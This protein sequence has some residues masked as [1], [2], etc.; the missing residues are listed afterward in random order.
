MDDFPDALF[1]LLV[2]IVGTIVISALWE[3]L[4]ERANSTEDHV[5]PIC[6]DCRS[7]GVTGTM[8]VYGWVLVEPWP[9]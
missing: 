3:E 8:L 1:V 5:L 6:S 4:S 9:A 2:I 7:H